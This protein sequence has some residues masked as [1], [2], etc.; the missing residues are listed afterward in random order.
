MG[1]SAPLIPVPILGIL[2]L[3]VLALL[4]AAARPQVRDRWPWLFAALGAFSALAFIHLLFF[5]QPY[6][7]SAL[8]PRGG[9]DLV[10]FF[11]PSHSFAAS[12]VSAGRLPFW[13]PHLFSGA[14]HLANFQTA[15]LYPPNLIAYL[16][17]DPFS[18]AALERLALIHFL[19]ASIGVYWLARAIG[20]AHP[21]AVLSGAIFAYSGFMVAHL[22]HYSMLSTATWA[23]WV[24]AAIVATV[25]FGS[26]AATLG[27]TL[28]L[29]VA[30]LGGHQPILLMTLTAAVVIALFE[31]WRSAEYPHPSA[32]TGFRRD[33]DLIDSVARLGFMALVALLLTAPV[34]GPS[35]EMLRYTVRSGL[36]Y[37]AAS[38]F[39]VQPVALLHLILPTVYGSNPTDYWGPFSNTEMWGYAGVLAMGLAAFGLLVWPS[40]TRAFWAVVAVVSILFLLGPF[41]SLHGWTYAFVPGYDQMR[42]AGRAYMFFDLAVAL[43]AG[44]GLAALIPRRGRWFPRQAVLAQRSVAVLA[45]ALIIVVA[46]VIPLFSTQVLGTNDPGN[47]PVIALDNVMLL[48]LWLM[49]GLGVMYSVSRGL[50]TGGTLVVAVSV[51]VLLDIFHA[52]A[53]FNPTT[54]PILAGFQH[55][56]AVTFLREEYEEEGPFRI[57]TIS[58]RWQPNVALV[59]GLDDIGGLFDPLAL[60]DYQSYLAQAQADRQSDAYKDLNVR[61]VVSDEET[62]PPGAGFD[63][64][65]TTADGLVLWEARE[66]M[67]R[68][69]IEDS[70]AELTVITHAP[71]HLT[72]QIPPDA[73][74]GRLIVS[75]VDYP[76][77]KAEVQG[78]LYAVTPYNS[79]LQAIELDEGA[80]TVEL[81]FRPE[82]WTLWLAVAAIGGLLWLLTAAV[83]VSHAIGWMSWRPRR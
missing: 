24:F 28:A 21:A 58:P 29:A 50:L 82:R 18:Y 25:R 32:W 52:T 34:L 23:P 61:Y 80:T 51:V 15:T 42:G 12:E 37:E 9:G 6:R 7:S 8:I 14:P 33:W 67:P 59:A 71:G 49:L 81:S 45:V 70:D 69:W 60:A 53:P 76:G 26:W 68:A 72:I 22:G 10:S 43:L 3:L 27:G 46:F 19:I 83:V 48:A 2:I 35:F 66:W 64:A 56:E 41:A 77:W 11:Y 31:L 1:R 30:V 47:R 62:G 16:L 39:A 17:S 78:R 13:N 57:E 74:P 4:V 79:V 54:E 5:W 73:V 55:E 36:S 75:Q 38:E 65:L 44:F 20:I 63:E 40:R